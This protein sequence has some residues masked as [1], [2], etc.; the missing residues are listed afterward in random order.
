MLYYEIGSPDMEL[1]AEDLKKGL[2]A[3]FDQLKGINK[4]LAI[5]PDYTRLPSRSGE[6]TEFT[7]QYY[8]DKLTDVLPALGTHTPMTEEQIAHM[9]GTLP[10]SLIR[11]HDW[12]N[13]VVNVG[14]VP[15][16]FVKE[17]SEGAVEFPWPAQVNKLL[18]SGNFD[19]ILSI[20]QV[21]P[22]EVVG[23]ANYNKNVF[24]GTG[25]VEGINKSHFIGAA[26][27]MERMMGHADTPV[28]KIFN[29]AS[30]NF[31][32][33]MPIL[34]V[35]TVVG[36]DKTD[37]KVKARGLFIGDDYEV[38]DK[39]ARL[40][41]QVNFEMLDK[42]LKKVVV[43]LDPTEFKSTWLGNKS[44]YRTRMAI[45]D[46]GELIVLA[47]ALKE[48]GED[49][50]IDRLI[51]KYGYFGTPATLK[52]CDENEELRHNLSAAAHLI[53]GSSEGRFSITY[54]PGKKPGNLTK[55]EIESVGFHY[56]D[57]DEITARYNPKKLKDGY[58]TLPNGEEIF[59]ISN[60]A[61]GLWA[62]KERFKY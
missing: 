20:G 12:R 25:G 5:P 54:C 47:P 1:T 55:E 9:F 15:A 24:V 42:P 60:P 31:T 2:Y 10:K 46:G 40:S 18:L 11:E 51:R 29:Y 53:H 57:I 49:K 43:W 44:V 19:L 62:F 37:G 13:D 16:E 36:L 34:Y 27:G 23:M 6:L 22:H 58:N 48:F 21:V 61:I 52:A 45:D 56:A 41:L 39:A 32:N 26:Y 38:F 3:A 14:E 50:E 17:V 7:W 8:G 33:H 28:R 35:Q 30:D 59:Y 4:V